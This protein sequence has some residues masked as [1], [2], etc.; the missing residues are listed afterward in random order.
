LRKLLPTEEAALG[1]A[2]ESADSAAIPAFD[3]VKH[4]A[5]VCLF[6]CCAAPPALAVGDARDDIRDLSLEELMNVEVTV[7]SRSAQPLSKSPAAVY[8]ITG[9]EIRRAGH[10]SVQEALRMVPG[11]LVGNWQT[12]TWDVTARGFTSGFNNN[13]LILIDGIN[14]YDLFSSEGVRWQTQLIDVEEIDRIEVV[15]GPGAALWGQN[16]VNGVVHVITKKAADTQGLKTRALIGDEQRQ[17]HVRYGASWGEDAFVRVWGLGQDRDALLGYAPDSSDTSF[18]D[19]ELYKA[20][21]RGDF[22]LDGGATLTVLSQAY[23]GRVG[24]QYDIGFPS[25]PFFQTVTDQTPEN[26]GSLAVAWNRPREDGGAD[27]VVTS[28]QRSNLR[29]VDF[30]SGQDIVDLDWQRTLPLND[31]HTLTF[32][33]GYRMVSS[34][35]DGDFAYAFRPANSTIGSLRAFALDKWTIPS[36]DL[37]LVAGAEAEYNDITGA[38]VQPTARALWAPNAE[39]ALWASIS[40]AVRI[41]SLIE[42]YRFNQFVDPQNPTDVFLD[43][44]NEHLDAEELLAVELGWRVRP[45]ESVALDFAAFYNDLDSLVTRELLPPFTQGPNTFFPQGFGNFGSAQAWGWEVALDAVLSERWRVRAA[46][47]RYGQDSEVDPASSDIGFPSGEDLTPE[48]IANV[49][50]YFD[51][52]QNWELDAA[53][54]YVD[55]MPAAGTPSYL[56]TDLRLGYAPTP[57]WRLTIGVQNAT[58]PDHPENGG[59]RVERNVWVGLSFGR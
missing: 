52:G 33:L 46:F 53:L 29:Q 16:A 25:A 56:R 58:D 1:S 5:R 9:D 44:G 15:R 18:Q 26:G 50:S 34:S 20:G 55:R 23:F 12:N 47:A 22:G 32:G 51:L 27:R 48:H 54:Y 13:M 31:R 41:P 17:G 8:V 4:L 10:S 39:H 19:S 24:E 42:V 38:E 11:M 49:R 28:Y 6:V 35:L 30:Q 45:S 2:S 36:L 40:R 43:V 59:F 21:F 7:A 14:V 57:D 3:P 37:E